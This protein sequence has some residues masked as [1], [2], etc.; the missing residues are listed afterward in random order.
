[1]ERNVLEEIEER[2]RATRLEFEAEIE[3]QL[4]AQREHFRY[5]LQ[6]GKVRFERDVREFQS[7]YRISLWPYIT[8]AHVAYVLTA[9]MIYALIVPLV[10]LD[11]S[12]TIYQHICFR[13]YGIPR[14]RRSAHV[15]IDRHHLAYLNG[16]EKLNCIYCGYANGVIAYA[17]EIAGRTE[18]FWCPVK[19][20]R[21]AVDPHEHF[22]R[23]FDYGDAQS[24]RAWLDAQRKG[25]QSSKEGPRS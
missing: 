24:Y 1:M 19:H 10:F 6:R 25:Q 17:R 15:I 4:K 16:I 13:A 23:F 21:R 14:V 12:V 3:R 5:R 20:A 22:N 7:R 11:L 9:P 2:L 8:R 18:A